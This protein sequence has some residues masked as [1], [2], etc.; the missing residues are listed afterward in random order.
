MSDALQ[1]FR[2]ALAARGIAPPDEIIADGRIHRCDVEGKRGKGDASYLLHLDGI[3]AGGFENFRDGLGWQNWRADTGRVLTPA[4]KAEH[5]ARVEA[6]QQQRQADET[7]RHEEAQRVCTL[8][9]NQALPVD[10]EALHPYL[11]RKGVQSHGLRVTKDGRL[12]VPIRDAAGTLHSLQFIDADGVKRFKT[13]GRKHGCY[14]AIGKPN[15]VL[16]IAEG[17]ATGA[18][19]H[20]ATGNAVAVAFDTGNLLRVAQA[21]RA[22]LPDVKIVLCAD[23]DWRTEGNPGLTKAREAARVVNGLVAVPDF[24]TDRPEGVSD[25]NDIAVLFGLEAV[26]RAVEAAIEPPK[27]IAQTSPTGDSGILTSPSPLPK[28]PDVPE[29]PLEL[30]PDDLVDWVADAAERARFR[31]EFAAVPC[32]AALGSLIGRKLGIRLKQRD[33]WTEYANVWGAIIGPPSALK[34]PAIREAMRPFKGLQVAAD[35]HH[36][37]ELADYETALEGYKLQ[38]CAK[39]KTAVKALAKNPEAEIDL[40]C[41]EPDK[42]LPGPKMTDGAALTA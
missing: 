39:R 7:A 8:I 3:P 34:S 5:R 28:L 17:Y 35:M 20:E 6:A 12:I 22:K 31:P 33:D 1:Q 25:F 26:R 18:S 21:L 15:D 16:C 10:L 41:E 23:D 9:W 11:A 13:G 38:K 27:R 32:M 14:Y 36:R 19:I 30:L 4:E 2:E 42:P 29:F 24:G 40:D 37:D